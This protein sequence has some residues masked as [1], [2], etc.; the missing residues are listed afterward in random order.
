MRFGR[1]LARW[2][3]IPTRGQSVRLRGW[4]APQVDRRL[5]DLVEDEHHVDV[6]E[7]GETDD[8]LGVEALRIELD[9]RLDLTPVV[10]VRLAPSA[11]HVA[12]RVDGHGG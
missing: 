8:G 4:R 3:K 1:A 2:A 12:D 7:V 6:R 5:V 11:S 9:R 10:V